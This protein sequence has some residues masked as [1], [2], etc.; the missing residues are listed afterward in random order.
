VEDAYRTGLG[1][2]QELRA[3]REAEARGLTLSLSARPE[4]GA[5]SVEV[6]LRDG[7]GR[8]I[9]AQRVVVR[10]E[11]PA[12]GGF[13]ADFALEDGGAGWRGRV[14]L[15]LPGRWRL[16]ATADL[17]GASLRRVFELDAG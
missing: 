12:E 1:L 4:G 3:R 16:V 15:P 6:E 14:P 2:N 13:D 7:A 11:R 17:E 9:P 5:W 10:R 8:R